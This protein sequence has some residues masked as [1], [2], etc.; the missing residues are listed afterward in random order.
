M[1]TGPKEP[2]GGARVGS[3]RKPTTL[4]AQSIKKLI[5]T[6]KIWAKDQGKTV[7][8]VLFGIIYDDAVL[9]NTRLLGI[10]LVKDYTMTK[11]AEGSEADKILGPAV[12]LP[13]ERPDPANVVPIKAA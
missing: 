9:P 11:L 4:S 3:G 5:K 7:D 12:Y 10:K 1:S 8:D 6:A 2:R 13:E